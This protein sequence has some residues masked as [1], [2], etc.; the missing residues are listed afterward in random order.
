MSPAIS[1]PVRSVTAEAKST[2]QAC[3]LI[4]ITDDIRDGVDGIT[5]RAQ[6]AARGGATMIQV[7]LKREKF[8]AMSSPSMRSGGAGPKTVIVHA[9]K[10][11]TTGAGT[12]PS[13]SS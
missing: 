3:R 9:G 2:Q 12:N 11:V 10:P 1:G 13:T 6:A 8:A 7:R 4:A 5:A